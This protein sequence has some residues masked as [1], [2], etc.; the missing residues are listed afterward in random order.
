ML[1]KK[2]YA[3]LVNDRMKKDRGKLKSSKLKL[4]QHKNT[5]NKKKRSVEEGLRSSEIVT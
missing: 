5:G 1:M 2:N 3:L 4:K